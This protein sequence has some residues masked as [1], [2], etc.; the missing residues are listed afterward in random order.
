[1][2]CPKLTYFENLPTLKV[3]Y[4]SS[5]EVEKPC[6]RVFNITRKEDAGIYRY[7]YQ[8]S[9]SDNEVKGQGNSYTTYFRSLDP[10]L[11]RWL[12]IDPKASS[13]PWQS[14]YCSMD[15]NPIWFNDPMG[16]K[17]D[18]WIENTETG[19]D[20]WDGDV[21]TQEEFDQSKYASSKDFKY[22]SDVDNANAYT[23]PSGE[24]KI[25]VN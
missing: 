18:G 15:N 6:T 3:T 1:M 21:N 19:E 4:S 25:I 16:D 2:G 5:F 7:G 12:S 24:G 13:L 11:G 17:V 23:L 9:E 10:R 14:P 22:A 8:G 20:T